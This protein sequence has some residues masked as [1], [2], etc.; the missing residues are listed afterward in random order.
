MTKID[1]NLQRVKELVA[2]TRAMFRREV[3][4][5]SMIH[6]GAGLVAAGLSK[7]FEKIVKELELEDD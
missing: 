4:D 2:K 7:E 3:L 6:H 5:M 1:E